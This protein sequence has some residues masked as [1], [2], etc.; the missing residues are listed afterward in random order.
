MPGFSGGGV[1]R[2]SPHQSLRA[3]DGQRAVPSSRAVG[4]W[5]RQ[6]PPLRGSKKFR[7]LPHISA[8]PRLLP[9]PNDGQL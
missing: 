1:T 3:T 6:T 8:M 4:G 5:A 7:Q 9:E 2:Y